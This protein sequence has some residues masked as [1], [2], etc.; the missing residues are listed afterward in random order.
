M[1]LS[2]F[3][4]AYC[5][6]VYLVW[7]IVYSNLNPVLKSSNLSLLLRNKMSS[8]I[9]DIDPLSD[10]WFPNIFSH[11]VGSFVF[12]FFEPT[13]LCCPARIQLSFFQ[14]QP[15]KQLGLWPVPLS[16]GSLNFFFSLQK[17]FFLSFLGEG[18]SPGDRTQGL[19]YN[20]QCY[21]TELYAQPLFYYY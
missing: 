20:R 17:F 6:S 4:C 16:W 13:S 9:L 1:M 5:L 11:F 14:P 8:Y 15:S 12:V 21:T 3:S 7:R 10:T 19:V 18:V 2:I